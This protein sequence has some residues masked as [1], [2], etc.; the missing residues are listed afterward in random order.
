VLR[1]AL[2]VVLAGA[3]GALLLGGG[4]PAS[5]A[6]STR[7]AFV[8]NDPLSEYAVGKRD[9]DAESDPRAGRQ[10][11]LPL[12]ENQQWRQVVETVGQRLASV[13][14]SD[15]DV[16]AW[17]FVVRKHPSVNAHAHPGG[18]ICVYEGLLAWLTDPRTGQVDEGR[19]AAVLA[20]EIAHV[21]RQHL[22]NA[23][24][25]TI[26]LTDFL[27]LP[28][29]EREEK[30]KAALLAAFSRANEIE[31]DQYGALYLV[32]AGYSF[33][34]AVRVWE[35]MKRDLGGKHADPSSQAKGHSQEGAIELET[36]PT[37]SERLEALKAYHAK[38]CGRLWNGSIWGRNC[39]GTTSSWRWPSKSSR[40]SS[41][42][43]RPAPRCGTTWPWLCTSSI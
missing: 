43:S 41:R 26:A 1:V 33:A 42:I 17:T 3:F 30:R 37:D 8:I 5:L 21:T 16:S 7:A 31:A 20:H 36:Y 9:F 19:L 38:C 27:R 6:Q 40:A 28:D 15:T 11:H 2:R 12:S 4:A 22:S 39:S 29:K 32:R 10:L 14:A 13:V 24:T 18:F 23:L 35:A 25:Q 34:D